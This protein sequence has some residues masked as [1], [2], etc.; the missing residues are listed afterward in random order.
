MLHIHPIGGIGAF[1]AGE[2]G[3]RIPGQ[4]P[5]GTALGGPVKITHGGDDQRGGGAKV[6]IIAELLAPGKD[7]DPIRLADH[8]IVR[9]VELAHMPAAFQPDIAQKAIQR[10]Q[11]GGGRNVQVEPVVLAVLILDLQQGAALNIAFRTDFLAQM[12]GHAAL[13]DGVPA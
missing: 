5:H 10:G 12:G 3:R 13:F 4:Q 7:A 2:N 11:G 8:L 6:I 9:Q 1:F